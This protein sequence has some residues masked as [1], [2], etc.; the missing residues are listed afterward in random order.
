MLNKKFIFIGIGVIVLLGLIGAG[1][2]WWTGTPEYSINQ[3]KKAIK[4]HNSELGLKY[5]DTDAIFENLWTN[6]KSEFLKEAEQAEEFEAI[7]IMFGLQLAE[8]MKPTLK[9]DFEEVIKSWFSPSTEEKPKEIATTKESL[10]TGAFWEK[11]LEIKKQGDSAYIELPDNTKI[12]L[13]KKAGKR[14]W[15]ISKIEGFIDIMSNNKD[16]EKEI[17][18]D[19]EASQQTQISENAKE[20]KTKLNTQTKP[21]VD[22]CGDCNK[23]DG[24][25]NKNAPYPCCEN[26]K[27]C[28]C[29]DQEYRDYYCSNNSCVYSI[30]K[31]KINKVNCFDCGPN[32]ICSNG[33]C[34]FRA[35]EGL[36]AIRISGG[37]WEN[38]DADLEKD[39]PVVEIVYL[40]AEGSIIANEATE[41][42]PI[43]ADVKVYAAPDVLTTPTKLVF[44]AHYSEEQIILG[45]I[46][47]RIRIP[48]EQ[49]SVNPYTDYQ[50]G[51][52]EVTVYTPQ[53]GSFSDRSDFIEL[54]E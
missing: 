30:T 8:N 11:D 37:L 52:V 19:N 18:K 50:Y 24:W 20:A 23:L 39:G 17:T 53:Q 49:M 25:V 40:D 51:A 31:N 4:T 14:Y 33:S 36:S 26:N 35:I 1:Y 47:P 10:R 54:Y 28:S 43:S 16:T 12:V 46:Y 44:S 38:W 34:V 6:M 13:T 29:Q 41:T 48:K 22:S 2:Y 32:Q 15:V 42:M 7:G 27:I 3:I 21:E 45:D 5:I 9:E